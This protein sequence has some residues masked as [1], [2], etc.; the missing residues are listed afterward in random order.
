MLPLIEKLVKSLESEG[1]VY[2]HWKS[3]FFMARAAQGEDDLDLLISH[4][5]RQVF[6]GV[7]NR[8]SFKEAWVPKGMK[9]IPG[10]LSYYGY[11]DKAARLVHVHVHYKLIL[12]DDA[13]KNYHLPIEEVYLKSALQGEFFRIPAPEF[14]FAV[15]VIRMMLKY[16]TWNTILSGQGKVSEREW[17]ELEYFQKK[18]STEQIDQILIKHLSFLKLRLFQDCIRSL[19]PGCPFWI[20]FK[21]G[22]RVLKAMRG[23]A[24]RPRAI[25]IWLQFWRRLELAGKRRLFGKI[26]RQKMK[27]GGLLVAFVGGDGAGKTT[28]IN[29]IADWLSP[30]IATMNIHMGKPSWSWTTVLVRGLLKVGRLLGFWPFSREPNGSIY[31]GNYDFFPGYPAL[32]REVCTAR[33]RRLSYLK[34]R[35]YA[36]KGFFV[37]CDRFPLPRVI[38]MDGPQVERMARTLRTNWY[39]RFLDKLE[40][41]YYQSIFLPDLL[42]VLKVDP[43]KAVKR[44]SDENEAFVRLRSKKIWQ[45][46]WGGMAAHIVD[47]NQPKTEVLNRIK[48]TLWSYV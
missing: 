27:N 15:F 18:V 24:R 34:A 16:S 26:P 46:D 19:Q 4:K 45:K 6:L 1:V 48:T 8:L 40:R 7:L 39:I 3:N 38:S 21:T 17:Q 11:D 10:I 12:G 9:K 43:D 32:I 36:D 35:R 37:L 22:H 2:C 42:F 5:S 33:D 28:A 20:R 29:G 47:T 23:C 41:K 31:D 25:D 14:E 44:K 30:P 13:T